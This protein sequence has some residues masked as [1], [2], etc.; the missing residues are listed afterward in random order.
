MTDTVEVDTT[1]RVI[2]AREVA[3]DWLAKF[4]AAA[5]QNDFS[6]VL[7]L[8]TE[9]CW[10]R[11]WLSVSWDL[12]TMHGLD[13]VTSVAGHRLARTG[14]CDLMIRDQIPVTLDDGVILAAFD[15]KT[16]VAAGRG[17]VRL[18]DQEDGWRARILFTTIDG[19][20]GYPE[21]QV[22]VDDG[23]DHPQ[24]E[25]R[26]LRETWYEYRARRGES[27]GHAPD[28]LVVGAGHAG[29]NTTA[30]LQHLGLSA[31][32]VEQTARV[33][34]VWR[35][36]YNN[37]SLHDSKWLGQMA[38]L[39]FPDS[40]PVFSPKE[41]VADWFEAYAWIMQLNVWTST[42][43]VSAAYDDTTERWDVELSRE[44]TRRLVSPKHLVLAT[45]PFAGNPQ[46]PTLPGR[47][48]FAG[49]VV[50][51][52]GHEGGATLEGR[53]VIVVG[54]GSSGFDVAEDAYLNGAAQVTMVQRSPTYVVST[55]NGL[56][57]AGALYGES[58]PPVDDADLLLNSLPWHL[59]LKEVAPAEV[60]RVAK[61][62]AEM[63]AGLNQA[64][65]RTT[66]GPGDTGLAGSAWGGRGYYIDKGA[67]QL[68]ID[69]KIKIQP[70]EITS[71]TP[72]GVVFSDGS[73]VSADLVVFATGFPNMRENLRPII[74]DDIAD[75]LTPIWYLDD[76]GEIRGVFRPTTHPRLWFAGGGF[77]QS[78]FGSRLLAVQIK[79]SEL[80]LMA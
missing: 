8:F 74:G 38:Y 32:L 12:R 20:L 54:A 7:A 5:G 47:E 53:R 23:C 52:S 69:G 49:D 27:L 21:Q 35:L 14:F 26:D 39:P 29:L 51:T 77:L 66:L 44:G 67:C 73:T 56:R 59:F 13:A 79:A 17:I 70:G 68:I 18:C 33:G 64:G 1:S 16:N 31:L 30:R 72:D 10:W 61:L 19:L 60:R 24:P 36:R 3:A 22:T 15:F 6:A 2:D 28:V 78:R 25:D 40:W 80:G 43:V 58:A 41:M 4:E 76:E 48:S 42:Q 75:R 65:F 46:P 9:D 11:D 57:A 63:L 34:D 62:D 71:Y 55:S 37:L 45:G 50:H